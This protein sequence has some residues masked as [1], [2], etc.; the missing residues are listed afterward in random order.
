MSRKPV[1][2]GK[3][4][5]TNSVGVKRIILTLKQVQKDMTVLLSTVK[6][7]KTDQLA[8]KAS[9]NAFKHEITNLT[10]IVGKSKENAKK[11]I[12]INESFAM[13][14]FPCKSVVAIRKLSEDCGDSA[15]S[16]Q[17]VRKKKLNLVPRSAVSFCLLS[18]IS[19]NEV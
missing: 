17:V 14:G 10:E 7:I 16:D 19:H 5:G 4:R 15:Y 11:T 1:A 9:I 8:I 12:K 6:K 18:Q 13:P 2:K 3:K